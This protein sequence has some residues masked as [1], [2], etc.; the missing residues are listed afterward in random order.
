MLSK[1]KNGWAFRLGLVS[2][3][4]ARSPGLVAMRSSLQTLG[5]AL[6]RQHAPALIGPEEKKKENGKYKK[7]PSPQLGR[8]RPHARSLDRS[9]AG[10]RGHERGCARAA[11]DLPRE[12]ARA[13]SRSSA[14]GSARAKSSRVGRTG[15][16]RY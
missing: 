4:R 15:T 11:R 3:V 5:L 10:A 9:S 2:S 8:G 13:R 16:L 6:A 7:N 12:R 1:K 14:C